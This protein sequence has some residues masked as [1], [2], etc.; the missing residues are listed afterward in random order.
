M[1]LDLIG[2]ISAFRDTK[3]NILVTTGTLDEVRFAFATDTGE[4]GIYFNNGWK[5]LNISGTPIFVQ[6]EGTPVGTPQVFNFVGPNVTASISGSVVQVFITG[7]SSSS[8][9]SCNSTYMLAGVPSALA[10]P[11]GTDWKVPSST[12]ASGSLAVFYNGSILVKG[13]QY[14]ELIYVSGTYHL[15]FTP[16]TG[17]THMVTYGVSCTTQTYSTGSGGGGS[18][19]TGMTDSN[20]VLM[21]DSN[22]IQIVDSNGN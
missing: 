14:E 2:R 18:T 7:S 12:F 5:W 9:P 17:A 4:W 10:T 21:V 22:G 15:L 11:T 1:S 6:D 20:G 19:G 16:A 8:P 13:T 3:N